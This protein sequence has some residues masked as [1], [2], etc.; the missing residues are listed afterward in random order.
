[1]ENSDMVL[2]YS[3]LSEID[4]LEDDTWQSYGDYHVDND[5]AEI[6]KEI[7]A[8]NLAKVP[9]SKSDI[10][11]IC[12]AAFIGVGLDLIATAG[13]NSDNIVG[14]T[15]NNIH[16]GIDHKGNP[17]DFQGGFTADGDRINHGSGIHRDI[18]FGGGEHRER[19]FDHD[20]FR[21]KH[22]IEDY[23]KGQ[24][25][26]G[27][28][29]GG[30]TEVGKYVEVLTKIN[31]Y[32]KEY[33][34][35]EHSDAVK[36]YLLHMFADFFSTKGLPLPGWSYLSHANDRE[37]RQIA[38]DLY[39]EGLNMRTELSKGLAVGVPQIILWIYFSLHY[40]TSE[41]EKTAIMQH[42][43]ICE[44]IAFAII[45]AVN[46]GKVIITEN[47]VGLNFLAYLRT[48]KLAWDCVKDQINY[49]NKV[50]TKVNFV[51][52]R[53]QIQL[54]NTIIVIAKGIYISSNYQRLC[55]YL[56]SDLSKQREKRNFYAEYLA[57]AIDDFDK[58][59][60]NYNDLW[61]DRVNELI[62][63]TNCVNIKLP[64]SC[65]L[66]EMVADS[67]ISDENNPDEYL[68]NS[69]K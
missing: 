36:A 28:F 56:L 4:P 17:I 62:E 20:L 48:F 45:S 40:R 67:P 44:L 26:D 39:H 63:Q 53:S 29:V 32:G 50:L 61:E 2:D 24:F 25:R 23:E 55:G 35:M 11:A 54:R 38:A 30:S 10:I 27:G 7:D 59:Y 6:Q 19:T 68:F 8:A 33:A 34:P 60:I 52:V 22:A 9:F 49:N 58:A 31:Q 1:M 41:Y 66:A 21:F 13:N 14:K 15:G 16:E 42:R 51:V 64:Q 47:P 46:A 12:A 43:H 37:I 5:L 65:Q 57:L 18:S 69:I 3:V